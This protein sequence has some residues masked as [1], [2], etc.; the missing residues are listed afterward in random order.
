MIMESAIEARK[1]H[2]IIKEGTGAVLLVGGKQY[3]VQQGTSVKAE[4][5]E[6]AVDDII[7]FKDEQIIAFFKDSGIQSAKDLV[8]KAQVLDQKRDKKIVV[9]KKKRRKGYT[10]KMGFRK[11]LTILKIIDFVFSS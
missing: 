10:R 11:E 9:F 5:I 7:E 1:R 4:F 2:S 6:A 8:I 3:L